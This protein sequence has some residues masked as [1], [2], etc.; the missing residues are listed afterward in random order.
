MGMS[1]YSCCVEAERLRDPQGISRSNI[2]V[3][4]ADHSHTNFA[5]GSGGITLENCHRS[6]LCKVDDTAFLSEHVIIMYPLCLNRVGHLCNT[7]DRSKGSMP[8]NKYHLHYA[9]HRLTIILLGNFG[10]DKVAMVHCTQFYC[11]KKKAPLAIA[12]YVQQIQAP[13][14]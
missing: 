8:D 3:L 13:L 5:W 14:L 10:N 2:I 7:A 1:P 12:E 9:C 6:L 11:F 4:I